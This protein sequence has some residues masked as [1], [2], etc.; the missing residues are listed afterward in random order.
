MKSKH[1]ETKDE[2]VIFRASRAAVKSLDV[3]AEMI[4]V[5]RSEVLRRLIPDLCQGMKGE[6]KCAVKQKKPALLAGRPAG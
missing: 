4:G 1:K 2:T 6:T 5:N 3:L